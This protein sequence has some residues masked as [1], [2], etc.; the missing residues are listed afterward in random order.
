MPRRAIPADPS[1]GDRIRTRRELRRWSARYAAS[2]AGVS[3]TTWLRIERGEQRTD[4][5]MVADLAAA[6]ECSVTELTGQPYMPADR[7]LEAAHIHAERVWRA[8]M[9]HPLTEPAAGEQPAAEALTQQSE[10]VRDLYN[11]CDYAGV[12][13]RLG[14]LIPEL[15]AGTTGNGV[16][17]ILE[18]MVPVYGVAM[19]SLLNIGYPA[20]AWLAAERSIEA[21]ERLDDPVAFGVATTN[22]ARVSAYSGAYAPAS[23]FC[24]QAALDL[25]HHLAAPAAPDVLGFLHLA[26][27][28]HAAGLH[29]IGAAEDHL[30]EAASLAARTGE[31]DSWDLSWGPTNVALWTVA[32]QLDTRR[33]G[34]ALETAAGV[35]VAGLPAVRQVYWYMDLARGCVD[36][37]REQDAVRM[38]LSAERVGPQHARSSAAARET[39]RSLLRQGVDSTEL[40][41]LCERMG[42]A[43]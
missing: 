6:L 37:R 1:I 3:H 22:R 9:A 28:H 10:L 2:R 41:G 36:V 42:V 4:R 19:G 20:H 12:L 35:R 32:F 16:R 29:D 33:S 40:R 11:R 15:H 18:L 14:H 26:R 30:A 31:T 23:R 17:E 7:Q 24:D 43:A 13:Q 27:A 8:M 39:A 25:D 5:Y 21:A 34:E 38:L